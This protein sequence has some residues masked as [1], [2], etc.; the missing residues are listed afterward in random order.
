MRHLSVEYSG[1]ANPVELTPRTSMRLQFH[2]NATIQAARSADSLVL[3]VQYGDPGLATGLARAGG[4][5]GTAA[6]RGDGHG[7]MAQSGWIAQTRPKLRRHSSGSAISTD[8][9]VLFVDKHD[10]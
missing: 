4:S 9:G 2:D 3:V 6:T 10:N 7:R 5:C 8:H 1:L